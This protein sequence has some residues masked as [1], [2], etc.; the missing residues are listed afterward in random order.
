MKLRLTLSAIEEGDGGEEN[1]WRAVIKYFIR[2][3]PR[4]IRGRRDG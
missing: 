4:V 2:V 1:A 3:C